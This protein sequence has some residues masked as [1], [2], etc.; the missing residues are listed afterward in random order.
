VDF[1]P[2]AI[3]QALEEEAANE[4]TPLPERVNNALLLAG[5]DYG[6]GEYERA[7]QQYEVVHRYAAATGNPTLAA[8][9]LNGLGEVKRALGQTEQ[10]GQFM[11]AALAPAALASPPPVPILLNLYANLGELRF[12]QHRWE[13]AE[14]YL[15]G[16]GNF[17]FLMHDPELRLRSW[18]KLGESQYRQNKIEAALNTWRNG[19][20][21]AGKLQRE[22]DHKEFLRLMYEHYLRQRD[23][24]GFRVALAGIREK[25]A[26]PTPGSPASSGS[27]G[28]A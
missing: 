13:E 2:E 11:Q 20:I 10:A 25:I 21:V 6:H 14:V 4:Q 12:G 18:K 15:Q 22:D 23:E 24:N 5:M 26:E 8:L 16:A 17:A 9:A 3:R 28:T 7:V 19:A 1:S 27:P